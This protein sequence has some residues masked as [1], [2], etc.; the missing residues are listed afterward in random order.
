[1]S[2]NLL[3]PTTGHSPRSLVSI[4]TSE[5]FDVMSFPLIPTLSSL[6]NCWRALSLKEKRVWEIKVKHAKAEH[7][8]MYPNYRFRPVHNKSKETKPKTLIPAE[9]ERRCE[10]VAQLRLEGM[11]GEE[12]ATA[13]E[14]LDRMRST[15]P[16]N[17]PRCPSS[18]PLPNSFPIA[19][20]ALTFVEPSR[21]HPQQMI[22]PR[23]TLP[24]R[25]SSV[26]PSL[27]RPWTEPFTVPRDPS[28]MPEINAS[29]F[30][31]VY[32]DNAF[33]GTSS[34][35]DASFVCFISFSLP[36]YIDD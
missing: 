3:I 4:P 2:L 14:R 23:H 6:G 28:P 5:R 30:N 9:D 22:H 20:P 19:I 29:L 15:T 35:Q 10:N 18:V 27:Y 24:R 31:G 12:L 16:I 21:P 33:P 25:P 17:L 13:V 7:K 34:Q 36:V 11:K 8:Q 1:M 32:L 26:G